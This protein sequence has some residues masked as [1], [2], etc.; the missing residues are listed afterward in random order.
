MAL[1]PD[2]Y[3]SHH[4]CCKIRHALP[5]KEYHFSYLTFEIFAVVASCGR[6]TLQYYSSSG[7]FST[8]SDAKN[9]HG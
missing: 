6:G 3:Y 4:S 2:W 9:R 7:K 8:A 5:F 1:S